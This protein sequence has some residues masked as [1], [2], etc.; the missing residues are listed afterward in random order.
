VYNFLL[1]NR[2]KENANGK[3]MV[4][5]YH[6]FAKSHNSVINL[7]KTRKNLV[8]KYKNMNLISD[9]NKLIPQSIIPDD[10]ISIEPQLIMNKIMEF[11]VPSIVYGEN[12][13]YHNFDFCEAF[14]LKCF[15]GKF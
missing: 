2:V 4:G 6:N 8:P 7:V 14:Y 12:L 11:S 9:T 15:K 13:V 5:I 3:I 10:F 1:D